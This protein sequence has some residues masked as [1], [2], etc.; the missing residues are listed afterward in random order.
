M[1]TATFQSI[2]DKIHFSRFQMILSK[3]CKICCVQ[4][5]KDVTTSRPTRQKEIKTNK[6]VYLKQGRNGQKVSDAFVT[7]SVCL[8]SAASSVWWSKGHQITS[9]NQGGCSMSRYLYVTM[10]WNYPG[11]SMFTRVIQRIQIP[12]TSS[13]HSS[14][15]NAGVPFCFTDQQ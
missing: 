14:C 10:F 5:T 11:S 13:C 12:I 8:A 4:W 7:R 2:N 9:D 6:A 3:F 1:G 15:F